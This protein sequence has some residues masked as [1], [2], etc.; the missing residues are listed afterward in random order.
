MKNNIKGNKY[1]NL[2]VIEIVGKAKNNEKL[3]RCKCDCGKE[4]I[5]RQSKII[6]GKTKSYGCYKIKKITERNKLRTI[7]PNDN[8]TRLY[9]IWRAMK[10]R[11]TYKSQTQYKDY[12]GRGI[13]ICKEWKEDFYKFKEW[14]LDNGYYDELTIDRIDVNGNYEPN[15][16]RWITKSEQNNNQRN[17]VIIEY[18]NQKMNVAQWAKKLN[19]KANTLYQRI[20]R[21]YSVEKILKEYK[22]VQ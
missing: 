8:K 9:R 4:T 1:N 13:V 5:V 10:S 6:S 14:A 16:C 3:C 22:E 12:G 21:N 20:Y 19:I 15:N 11:T 2:T 7:Y 17:N 18:K